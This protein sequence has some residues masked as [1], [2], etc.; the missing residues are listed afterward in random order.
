M[1]EEKIGLKILGWVVTVLT[2][3]IVLMLAVRILITP[4]FAR[5][6]YRIPGFPDDPFGFSLEDRLEWSEPSIRYL[7]NSEDITYLETLSF[8]DGEPIFNASELSH[9]EDVKSVVTGMRIA[10]TVL[11]VG[12]LAVV[13]FAVRKGWRDKLLM[14]LWRGGWGVVGMIAAILLF[15][16]LS[17][18]QLFTWFHQ[19][20]FTSG[21]W[22]FYTS[23]TLIRLFPMRFWQDAFIAVG[24]ISLVIG[25]LLII[26]CKPKK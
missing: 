14:A 21:T 15:V 24:T 7:V 8:A 4:T 25:V 22:Q 11:M 26:L 9:M 19:V 13:V 3:I 12:L 17:F 2:P 1:K 6:E 18:D 5:V 16:A 23:D 20:F 10:L